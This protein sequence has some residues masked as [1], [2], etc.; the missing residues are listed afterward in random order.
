MIKLK[1]KKIKIVYN[2]KGENKLELLHI[3][4]GWDEVIGE[5]FKKNYFKKLQD[6]LDGEYSKEEIYPLREDI[7]NAFKKTSYEAVKVVILGQDPYPNPDQAHGLA[8]SVTQDFIASCGRFPVSL[9]NIFKEIN[10]AYPNKKLT[11]ADGCLCRWA[12]QGVLLLNT[13]LTVRHDSAGSHLKEWKKFTSTVIEKIAQREKPVI[14]ILWGNDAKAY[15]NLIYTGNAQKEK[16]ININERGYISKLI[17]T[18]KHFIFESPHPAF[19]YMFSDCKHFEE[20]N[21]IISKY[22]L[23]VEID[24]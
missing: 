18:K 12:K 2:Y 14:F 5:E 1:I 6:F 24:W 4:N 10:K 15:K 11:R 9:N 17:S 20:V 16:I 7:F 13:A 23:G 22:N 8:F 19:G 21:N 3:K